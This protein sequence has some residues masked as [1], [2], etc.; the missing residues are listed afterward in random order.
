M[1]Q[2][3]QA[4]LTKF[5]MLGV[6]DALTHYITPVPDWPIRVNVRRY[7]GMLLWKLTKPFQVTYHLREYLLNQDTMPSLIPPGEYKCVTELFINDTRKIASVTAIFKI[8][9][10]FPW[11]KCTRFLFVQKFKSRNKCQVQLMF[12]LN[13]EKFDK[14]P[15]CDMSLSTFVSNPA[16]LRH[17]QVLQTLHFNVLN[18]KILE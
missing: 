1:R 14:I 18:Q 11:G 16:S 10:V 3:L 13:P 6:H 9:E 8:T 4:V 12:S 17:K 2:N 5:N 15:I 7:M